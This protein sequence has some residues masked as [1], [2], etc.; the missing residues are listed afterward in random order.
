MLSDILS[1]LKRLKAATEVLV[2][3]PLDPIFQCCSPGGRGGRGRLPTLAETLPPLLPPKWNYTL[4]RGLWRAAILSPSQPSPPPPPAHSWAPLPPPHFEK[5]GYA[6]AIF[7][8]VAAIHAR[9]TNWKDYTMTSPFIYLKPLWFSFTN[10]WDKFEIR[11]CNLNLN[12]KFNILKSKSSSVL[13]LFELS[14]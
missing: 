5:S 3:G 11:K 12:L 2:F 13:H 1:M 9:C 10:C 6:P 4:Y 8:C 14:I 7:L